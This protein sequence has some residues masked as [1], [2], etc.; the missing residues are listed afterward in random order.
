MRWQSQQ[1][2]PYQGTYKTLNKT[3]NSNKEVDEYEIV[4]LAK[5]LGITLDDMKEMSFVSL[6]NILI[7]SVDN[8]EDN[9]ATQ[10]DIDRYFGQ[11]V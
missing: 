2:L 5:R 6:M 7:S 1:H 9:Q 4:A 3:S 11:E 8:E 10:E